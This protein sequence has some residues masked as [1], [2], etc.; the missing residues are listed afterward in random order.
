M[1]LRLS[2]LRIVRLDWS[3]LFPAHVPAAP[4]RLFVGRPPEK[5]Q[6]GFPSRLGAIPAAFRAC[7]VTSGDSPVE[8]GHVSFLRNWSVPTYIFSPVDFPNSPAF[9]GVP[10]RR[11]GEASG[12]L[13]GV[14]AV[15]GEGRRRFRERLL[16][17][18]E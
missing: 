6:P 14:V 12:L 9:L 4:P 1:D 18:R 8:K 3:L 5:H 13:R 2:G 11:F 15:G 10:L 7:P 17:G 16:E